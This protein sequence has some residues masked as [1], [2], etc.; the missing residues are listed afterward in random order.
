MKTAII[1]GGKGCRAILEMIVQG[2]LEILSPEIVAVVDKV[3]DVPG[4]TYAREQGWQTLNSIEEALKLPGLELVVELTGRDDVLE[5]LYR[6]IPPGIRVMDH[7]VARVFWDLD[8][9]NVNLRDELQQKIRYEAQLRKDRRQLQQILDSIPDAVVVMNRDM[10]IERINARFNEVTGLEP[11]RIAGKGCPDPFCRKHRDKPVE[12]STC[13]FEEVFETA[14]PVQFIQ[15]ETGDGV[16]EGYYEITATPVFDEDGRVVRVVETSRQ[17]TEQIMLKRETEESERRFR[18]FIENAHDMITIKDTGGLYLEINPPAAHLF[19][20]ET[21]DFIG[22]TD[23]DIFPEKLARRLS[24]KDREVLENA[25]HMISEEKLVLKGREKFLDTVRFPIV[26]Y[27]GDVTGVC[28]ISR[29]VTEHKR[30]QEAVVQSEKL[31]AVGKL[32]AGVA[33]ELNN[34]L[35]GILSFAEELKMDFDEDDPA[36]ADLDI[37]VKETMRCRQIVRDLLDYARMSKPQRQNMNIN[38]VVERSL[39]L[40]Q[41]QA[42]F[43]DI[44]FDINLARD[45]PR[46]SV[47][48]NQMQQVFLNLIINAAEAMDNAGKITIYSG[49]HA[50]GHTVEVAVTDRGHG[51]PQKKMQQ[52]FEPF[53]STKG[54]QGNGL[55]LSVVQSMVEQHG[56]KIRVESEVGKGSTFKIRLP[57]VAE[58]RRSAANE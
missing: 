24:R 40:V 57:A 8:K 48:P 23:F 58:E 38:H 47:D 7:L 11:S 12:G 22:R 13:P 30:L 42:S 44:E 15:F 14:Q 20:L 37:I 9:V 6:L 34:P 49:M 28:S 46:V 2:R 50:D 56:G 39:S 3:D 10:G 4:M 33:H 45:L 55:G 53:Y 25:K 16:Q 29:D 26:D 54:Q 1:G 18:Q 5:D 51:I 19:G 41:K 43:H 31:A 35:T 21:D 36:R 17:I 27:K 32:A 52:I